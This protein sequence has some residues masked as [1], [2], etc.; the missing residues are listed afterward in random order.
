MFRFGYAA[1]AIAGLV[2]GLQ[3]S[4]SFL[5]PKIWQKT[6]GTGPSPD[7]ARK[8]AVELFPLVAPQL[9]RKKDT[10]RADAILLAY[11][12]LRILHPAEKVAA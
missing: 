11:A 9:C 6:S 4:Y 8:R 10:G 2:A 12:G 7:Q 1:G 3:L 5:L